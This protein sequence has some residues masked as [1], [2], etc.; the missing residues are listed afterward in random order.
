MG[1]RVGAKVGAAPQNRPLWGVSNEIKICPK[2]QAL[3]SWPHFVTSSISGFREKEGLGRGW[4]CGVPDVQTN[5]VPMGPSPSHEL[6][7]SAEMGNNL[8]HS[9]LAEMHLRSQVTAIA[10]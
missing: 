3:S 9:A 5:P 1:Q 6:P 7:A 10:E 2:S 8:H 4:A